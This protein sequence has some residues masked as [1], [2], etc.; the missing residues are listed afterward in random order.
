MFASI[1]FPIVDLRRF[2]D[3]A[4]IVLPKPSWPAPEEELEYVRSFG[5]I[6]RRPLGGVNGWLGESKIC[7]ARRL[8]SFKERIFINSANGN[9]LYP[10]WPFYKRLFFDGFIS[11]KVEIGFS[12]SWSSPFTGGE[13]IFG[14]NFAE[15]IECEHE[16]YVD[17]PDGYT[18]EKITIRRLIEAILHSSISCK[19]ESNYARDME[20]GSLNKVLGNKYLYATTPTS[21]NYKELSEYVKIGKTIAWIELESDEYNKIDNLNFTKINKYIDIGSTYHNSRFGEIKIIVVRRRMLPKDIDKKKR[22]AAYIRYL[23]LFFLRINSD[24][25]NMNN[26]FRAIADGRVNIAPGSQMSDA[27]QEFVLR[28]TRCLVDRTRLDMGM[29]DSDFHQLVFDLHDRLEPGVLAGVRERVRLFNLRPAVNRRLDQVIMNVESLN[30]ENA[31]MVKNTQTFNAPV[32]VVGDNANI[33]AID[34][35]VSISMSNDINISKE[36]VINIISEISKV[37]L[38]AVPEKERAALVIANEAAKKGDNGK[39]LSYLTAAGK[40][41]LKIVENAGVKVLAD[42]IKDKINF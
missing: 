28:T 21:I 18:D 5:P 38:N 27:T 7:D 1:Q 41:G 12:P 6:K 19:T 40:W 4:S 30:V 23:R 33:N 31:I 25:A 35:S 34:Q 11:A 3:E 8:F 29:A 26:L 13:G 16:N 9:P 2:S 36:D 10:L 22:I 24:M 15:S 37:D 17:K 42:A 20:F 39:L 14:P 32:G